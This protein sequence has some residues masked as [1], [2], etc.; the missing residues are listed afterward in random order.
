MSS[1]PSL[2]VRREVPKPKLP[3]TTAD[4]NKLDA[5]EVPEG[6]LAFGEG[7]ESPG[8]SEV[9]AATLP[10]ASGPGAEALG[11][12]EVALVKFPAWLTHS[13]LD[14]SLVEM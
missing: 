9:T 7:L 13:W 1:P 6:A 2:S 8:G 12:E 11:S 14:Q 4:I 5:K 3:N 10:V